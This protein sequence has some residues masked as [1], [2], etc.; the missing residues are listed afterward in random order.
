MDADNDVGPG[1]GALNAYRGTESDYDA[2]EDTSLG[3][4]VSL[5][6]SRGPGTFG[7]IPQLSFEE[8]IA[9]DVDANEIHSN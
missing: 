9:K 6:Y 4:A 3:L 8:E 5:S 7:L 1:K 2:S